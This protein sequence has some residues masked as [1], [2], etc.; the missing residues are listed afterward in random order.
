MIE[1]VGINV[2]RYLVFIR[3]VQ[4]INSNSTDIA[5]A[6][7]DNSD[8]DTIKTMVPVA[9]SISSSFRRGEHVI[10]NDLIKFF[11]KL[12]E[13]FTLK[14]EV[15]RTLELMVIELGYDELD[16]YLNCTISI[17]T[18]KIQQYWYIV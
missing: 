10:N 2:M 11:Q 3:F 17:R 14:P 16:L 12:F 13:D 4:N 8:K 15:L 9:V 6:I 18:I 1:Y 5:N 7:L